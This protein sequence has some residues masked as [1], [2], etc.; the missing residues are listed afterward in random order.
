MPI[1]TESY[2]LKARAWHFYTPAFL[3]SKHI[4]NILEFVAHILCICIDAIEVNLPPQSGCIE[5]ND[6]PS[7]VGWIFMT[8]FNPG[9]KTVHEFIS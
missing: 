4:T 1:Q 3:Q 8:N 7:S 6:S 2:L 5:C 9:E